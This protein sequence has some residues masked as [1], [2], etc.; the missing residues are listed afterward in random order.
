MLNAIALQVIDWL[1]NDFFRFDDGT[2]TLDVRTKPTPRESPGCPT[3]ST[4]KAERVRRRR[5][6]RLHRLLRAREP[7]PIR[8]P[9]ACIGTQRRRSVHVRHQRRP[10]GA[11]RDADLR[12]DRRA[13]RAAVPARRGT[14]LRADPSERLR[15]HRPIGVALSVATIRSGSCSPACLFG[16]LEAAGGPL[17]L[18]DIPSF[19]RQRHPGHHA[20]LGRHRQRRRRSLVRQTDDRGGRRA[21]EIAGGGTQAVTA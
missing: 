3:S 21:T 4:D 17:Q 12:R 10:D 13:R 2:G 16:F 20:A 9:A 1:F 5:P 15:I 11:A 19:D 7:E 8:I 6:A 18:E 14:L